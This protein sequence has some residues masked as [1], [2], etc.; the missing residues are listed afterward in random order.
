MDPRT[1]RLFVFSLLFSLLVTG[2]VVWFQ[3]L[4]DERK[5]FYANLARQA[6]E[7]PGR[8]VA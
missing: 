5:R 2:V 7:L 1:L 6:P 3:R 8:Y 4:P